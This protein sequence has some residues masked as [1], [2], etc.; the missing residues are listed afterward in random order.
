MILVTV[1]FAAA[2]IGVCMCAMCVKIILH[3]SHKFPETSAGHNADMRKLGITCPK[4][5]DAKLHG[6]ACSTCYAQARATEANG[7]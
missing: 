3:P 4:V 2:V 1:A 7:E 5:D 6:T